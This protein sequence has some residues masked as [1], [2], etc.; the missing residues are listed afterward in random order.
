M[1]EYSEFYQP[2]SLLAVC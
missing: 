2:R 1:M